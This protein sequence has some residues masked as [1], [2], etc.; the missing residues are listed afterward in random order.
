MMNRVSIIIV[1][2]T[3]IGLA[4]C[5]SIPRGPLTPDEL[6][7][8]AR[9]GKAVVMV[10]I[11]GEADGEPI[12]VFESSHWEDNLAVALGGFETGGEVAP[13]GTLRWVSE[14]ARKEGWIF[15]V[16]APGTHYMALQP[17]RLTGFFTYQARWRHAPRWRIEVPAGLRAGY[18]G[19]LILPGKASK[20]AFGAKFLM[21]L[22]P[23][24][25]RIVNHEKRAAELFAA[26]LPGLGPPTRIEMVR[27]AG[28]VIIRTP[29][30]RKP[31]K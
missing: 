24:R 29:Q 2:V 1:L 7:D 28:P 23:G 20:W 8:A 6:A 22:A 14:A 30:A 26:H 13:L 12:S 4:S 18:G 3:A 19:T 21:F 9:A 31:A 27:H 15:F 5:V 10:R 17:P 16:L 11:L 25:S